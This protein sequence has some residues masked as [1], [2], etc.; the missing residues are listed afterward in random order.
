VLRDLRENRNGLVG[1]WLPAWETPA[2]VDASGRGNTA[3]NNSSTIVSS[4]RGHVRKFPGGLTRG[5]TTTLTGTDITTD[6][7]T[8][9]MWAFSYLGPGDNGL[10]G[11]QTSGT[12]ERLYM[13][14]ESSRAI[15]FGIGATAACLSSASVY[16]DTE[17]QLLTGVQIGTSVK[18]YRNGD[19]IKSVTD[20]VGG[21]TTD[22]LDVGSRKTTSG[23]EGFGGRLV[24]VRLYDRALPAAE[25]RELYERTKSPPSPR[26]RVYSVTAAPPAGNRR[27]R[28][29]L[30]SN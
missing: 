28:V 8:L 24:D 26:R 7:I 19:L 18:L 22:T 2:L 4:S 25:V 11:A 13:R 21:Y 16:V 20:T 1:H 6:Q 23:Y 17:W 9:S 5:L 14:V 27:R 15:R 30:G 12:F 29:L 3:T 10:F